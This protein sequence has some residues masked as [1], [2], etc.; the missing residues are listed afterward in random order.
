MGNFKTIIFLLLFSNAFLSAKSELQQKKDDDVNSKK[1]QK[2]LVLVTAGSNISKFISEKGNWQ[3][4]YSVGLTFDN[5]HN[6]RL[7]ITL[8]ISFNRI[9]A[10]PKEIKSRSFPSV[11]ENIYRTLIDWNFSVFYLEIP[12]LFAYKIYTFNNYS[13]RFILGPGLIFTLN[14][15]SNVKNV[16]KTDEILGVEEY[17]PPLEP[18]YSLDKITSSLNT[19][20]RLQRSRFYFDLIYS[21]NPNNLKKINKI[22]TLSL[23]VSFVLG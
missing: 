12:V 2:T 14:D 21:L 10:L 19:G 13:L 9:N 5:Y 18:Q 1:N 17:G 11:G 6:N 8:P 23:K 20:I 16:I 3:V 7:T 15:N 22:N 4:G